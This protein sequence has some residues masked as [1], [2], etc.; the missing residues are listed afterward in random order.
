MWPRLPKPPSLEEYRAGIA[1]IVPVESSASRPFWSVMIPTY[2]RDDYLRRTLQSVLQQAPSEE[3][4]QIEVL[5]NASD[6]VDVGTIVR[7]VGN[8]RVKY[9]RQPRNVEQD[10]YNECIRRARGYWVHILHDDDMVCP[11]FYD[12]Y[13]RII[14]NEPDVVM[15]FGQVRV[16]DESDQE[17]GI[18]GPSPPE[19][20]ARVDGFVQRQLWEQLVQYCGAVTKREAFERAGGFCRVFGYCSDWDLWL[21]VGMDGAVAMVPKPMAKYRVHGGA[22]RVAGQV[23]GLDVFEVCRFLQFSEIRSGMSPPLREGKSWRESLAEG[24]WETAWKF[25]AVGSTLGRLNQARWVW[26]LRPGWWALAFYMKSWLRH[27][28]PSTV[29]SKWRRLSASVQ[30][31]GV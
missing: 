16:I 15:V 2:N 21:R 8:G 30:R 9:F 10:N 29:S 7:E 27:R 17:R 3:E 1:S 5:D 28:L 4:M 12:A 11:G 19:R 13:E 24:A 25:D 20:S 14:S 23:A 31:N 22:G 26:K 6:A 18:M